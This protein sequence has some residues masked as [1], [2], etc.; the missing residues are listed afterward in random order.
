MTM[1]HN[2]LSDD[3]ALR[4]GLAS[5][6]LSPTLSPSVLMSGLRELFG[7]RLPD[8]E[9][10]KGVTPCQLR[11]LLQGELPDLTGKRLKTALHWL[12]HREPEENLLSPSLPEEIPAPAVGCVRVAMATLGH[13]MLDGH[14][15]TCQ[16]FMIY[17]VS[18][19]GIHQRA[20]RL[21]PL[22]AEGEDKVASRMAL[23]QD[24]LIVVVASIGGPA[25]ARLTR[26][27]LWPIKVTGQESSNE[28]LSTFRQVLI[29]NP[30]PW[31]RRAMQG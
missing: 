2:E 27:G 21:V 18:P 15:A 9:K 30:P 29:S 12:T 31:L 19:E 23:I 16:G 7:G 3:L 1:I 28:W 22:L 17:D 25:A 13:G 24:C 10:L 6:E 11:P 14:F 5:R 8:R 20:T 4:I 26:A